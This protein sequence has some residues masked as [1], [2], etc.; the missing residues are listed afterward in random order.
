MSDLLDRAPLLP[1]AQPPKMLRAADIRAGM[2]TRWAAPEYA[3]MWEVA[4]ATGARHSRLA[5]AV[6]MSLWPSRGLELHG[7]EIK[8]SRADWRREAL[9]P[10]KA[11]KIAAY[12]DRWW[13]TRRPA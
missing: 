7:V 9:T 2:A 13:S 11:E 6:M 12:C 4:D 10:Q 5:D 8:V 1:A 3:I